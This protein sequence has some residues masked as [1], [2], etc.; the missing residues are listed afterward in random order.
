MEFNCRRDLAPQVGI[1]IGIELQKRN[2]LQLWLCSSFCRCSENCITRVLPSY[3]PRITL[4]LPSYYPRITLVLPSYYPRIT[5]VLPSYYPR[6][7]LVLPSYYP[8]ITLRF[9]PAVFKQHRSHD[10]VL[11][12]VACHQTAGRHD[13]A[14]RQR[15]A[16]QCGAAPLGA[17]PL[18]A[19]LKY[20]Q[21]PHLSRVRSA[22]K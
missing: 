3:Y 22:A 10:V 14:L 2:W 1:G 4:V 12:C 17:A 8:R 7:T 11:L 18:G 15:L 9:F 21:D 19:D 20:S 5:L 13:T 6:I 16:A